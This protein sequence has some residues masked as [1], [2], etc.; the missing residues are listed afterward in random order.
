MA[1]AINYAARKAYGISRETSLNTIKTQ[2]RRDN[3][4]H[5]VHCPTIGRDTIIKSEE[6]ERYDVF[7]ATDEEKAKALAEDDFKYPVRSEVKSSLERYRC[8]SGVIFGEIRCFFDNICGKNKYIYERASID[9]MFVDITDFCYDIE[10]IMKIGALLPVAN[11]KVI[12]GDCLTDS[13]DSMGKQYRVAAYHC[14]KL[15]SLIKEKLGFSISIGVAHN[16][17]IAK[18]AAS[19]SKPFGLSVL[20]RD[21]VGLFCKEAKVCKCRGFGGKF[22][23]KVKVSRSKR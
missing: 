2:L 18:L 21:K 10:N 12:H 22:G 15:R 7:E 4:S 14:D 1:L 13:D 23:A 6:Q 20:P 5:I 17:M 9:E 8:A 19:K 3:N 16:K 11:F